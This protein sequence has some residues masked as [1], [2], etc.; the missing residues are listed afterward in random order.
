MPG[1]NPTKLFFFVN[2]YF[3]IFSVAGKVKDDTTEVTEGK[4]GGGS[5]ES[6]NT[7]SD[8]YEYGE[9]E[10]GQL[11]GTKPRRTPEQ[12]YRLDQ[13]WANCGPRAEYT[14]LNTCFPCYLWGLSS[15]EI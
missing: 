13:G 12:T 15:L 7:V 1:I 5:G 9:S 3:S 10:L 2:A 14:W 6:G 8:D 11:I 4:R